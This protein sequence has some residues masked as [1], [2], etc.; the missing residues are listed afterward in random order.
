[1]DKFDGGGALASEDV[2]QYTESKIV[3]TQVT[4]CSAMLEE[5][6]DFAFSITYSILSAF[7]A[8]Q[9]LALTLLE[10]TALYLPCRPLQ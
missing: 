9:T 10:Y 1:M 4:K 3:T 2:T 6:C 5:S 8:L 7:Q